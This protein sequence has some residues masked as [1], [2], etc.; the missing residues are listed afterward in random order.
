[1]KLSRADRF[2]RHI[3]RHGDGCWPWI[4]AHNTAGYGLFHWSQHPRQC[5]GAHRAAY[6]LFSGDIPPGQL[7]LHRCDNPPCCNP[8]HLFLGDQL[9]N[10][11]DAVAKGRMV[12]G[13]SPGRPRGAGRVSAEEVRAIREDGRHYVVIAHH[14]GLSP[15]YVHRIKSGARYGWIA[16]P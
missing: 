3:Q 1:M 5:I 15:S 6:L 4:G 10:V 13:Q 12:F 9:A 8:A 16:V 7:V 2:L 11:Q 14:Y